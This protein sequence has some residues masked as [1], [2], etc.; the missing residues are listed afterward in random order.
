MRCR[1]RGKPADFLG[2]LLHA[3][4]RVRSRVNARHE[5]RHL[6]LD[7]QTHGTFIDA[8]RGAPSVERAWCYGVGVKNAI[9]Q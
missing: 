7:N 6:L 9:R 5:R 8:G 1:S 4:R 3:L 2:E